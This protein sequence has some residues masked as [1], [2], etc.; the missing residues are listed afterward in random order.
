MTEQPVLLNNKKGFTLV[1]MMIAMVI[2]LVAVLGLVQATLLSIDSNVRNLFRDEAVRIAE[3]QMN[4]LKSLPVSDTNL[5]PGTTCPPPL[6]TNPVIRNF[7]DITKN[8]TVCSSISNILPDGTKKSVQVIVG[9]NHKKEL[10]LTGV[11]N[12]EYQYSM[13]SIVGSSL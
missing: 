11:T 2:I 9:W 12:T 4:V 3:E 10:P 5:P 1:E 13:T 8:Y 7:R 6:A